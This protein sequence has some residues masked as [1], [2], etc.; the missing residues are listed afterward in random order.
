MLNTVAIPQRAMIR[1]LNRDC[2]DS[3]ASLPLLLEL[4]IVLK[5]YLPSGIGESYAYGWAALRL[6]LELPVLWWPLLLLLW[7]HF[8]VVVG[9]RSAIILNVDPA[10]ARQF[11]LL[12]PRSVGLVCHLPVIPRCI[13]G[14]G[15]WS[16]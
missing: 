5:K 3:K 6:Q 2:I 7:V 10:F 15:A 12:F 13:T 14:C 8:L 1:K 4:V 16:S 9:V 11:D